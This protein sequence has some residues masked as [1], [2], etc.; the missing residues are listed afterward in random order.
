MIQDNAFQKLEIKCDDNKQYG[1]R[2]C[3]RIHSVEYNENN[4]VNF[5]NK[6]ERHC[7]EV[8]VKFD[9]NDIDSL[10]YVGK[11]IFITDSEKKVRSIIIKF[12]S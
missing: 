5:M 4:D 2:L 10:H 12:K 8:C 9:L 11:P 3:V 7:D 1:R 6:V